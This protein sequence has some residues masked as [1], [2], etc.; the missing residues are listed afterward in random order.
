MTAA[1]GWEGIFIFH[2]GLFPHISLARFSLAA[3]GHKFAS[4]M[5]AAT[6]E[7]RCENARNW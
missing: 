1:N 4:E 5:H 6:V 3:A 7:F 2:F